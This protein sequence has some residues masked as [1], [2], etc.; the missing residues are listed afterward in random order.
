MLKYGTRL[1]PIVIYVGKT[2]AKVSVLV[3][4]EGKVMVTADESDHI[5]IM[6]KQRTT[7]PL[8]D[9]P[10]SCRNLISAKD[11]HYG[12][13]CPTARS[14]NIVNYSAINEKRRLKVEPWER[15]VY[16]LMKEIIEE[17]DILVVGGRI[18]AIKTRAVDLCAACKAKR[19]SEVVPL[20]CGCRGLCE[21]CAESSVC[22]LCEQTVFD[23]AVVKK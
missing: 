16:R 7:S 21:A 10:S 9:I 15:T 2:G 18:I 6:V 17:K 14:C 1:Q 8:L 5:E 19:Q 22:A 4:I 11:H 3:G 12:K 13:G 20:P 23:R